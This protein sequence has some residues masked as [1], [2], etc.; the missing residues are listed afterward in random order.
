[1]NR[2][3]VEATDVGDE[4]GFGVVGEVVSLD[5]GEFGI[6]GDVCLRAQGVPDPPEAKVPNGMD[7]VNGPDGGGRLVDDLGVDGIHETCADLTDG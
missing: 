6:D 7:A 3:G 1:M 5:D 2:G 4:V